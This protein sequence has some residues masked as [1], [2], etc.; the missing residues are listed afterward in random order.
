MITRHVYRAKAFVSSVLTVRRLIYFGAALLACVIVAA[1][2]YIYFFKP[3]QTN[4]LEEAISSLHFHPIT[5]PTTLRAPG[6]I[7]VIDDDGEVE[8]A[9]C[10]VDAKD[11][12]D[13]MRQSPTETLDKQNLRKATLNSSAKITE[14]L[15]EQVKGDV[16][17][18]VSF[19]LDDVSVLEVSIANLRG[20]SAKLQD[21]PGCGDSVIS[22]IKAGKHLCQGQ[23][24]L[25]A[26][27]TYTITN[28][29]EVTG[30]IAAKLNDAIRATIDPKA[31]FDGKTITTGEGLFY[32][33]RLAPLCMAL[34]D[35]GVAPP[36]KPRTGIAR[37]LHR[38]GL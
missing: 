36:P 15:K 16:I 5:P 8:S 30:E 19:T 1:P 23:Q 34:D 35:K 25:K 28:K 3:H 29:R 22:Y 24:V 38:V 17:E 18:S 32:G 37:L 11:L 13:V 31:S 14:S 4:Y 27:A 2:I 7:Y 26:T 9:L 6:T 10:W 33:M 12:I 20:L 21:E